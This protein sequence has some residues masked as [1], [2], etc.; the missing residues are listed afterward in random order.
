MCLRLAEDIGFLVNP[1]LCL[2][3]SKGY[4]DFW[5]GLLYTICISNFSGAPLVYRQDL[6]SVVWLIVEIELLVDLNL[7][8]I[9]SLIES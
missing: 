8:F 4:L 2:C 3:G 6:A 9:E 7:C 1:H 5:L